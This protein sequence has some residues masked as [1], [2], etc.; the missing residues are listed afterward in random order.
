[1]RAECSLVES[2]DPGDLNRGLISAPSFSLAWLDLLRWTAGK[3]I[4]KPA[5]LAWRQEEY[6]KV[7][8][9]VVDLVYEIFRS[10]FCATTVPPSMPLPGSRT[11]LAFTRPLVLGIL[12]VTPDSF[13]DGGRFLAA[14]AAVRRAEE[15]RAEGADALDLGAESTRPGARAVPAKLQKERLVP[16]LKALR[17]N[18]AFSNI[19][20]SV[21]T[22][23][24]EVA[25]ACLGEGADLI[26]DIS[27]LCHD[28]Q[29]A[30]VCAKAKAPVILMHMQ[31]TP[32]TMQRDPQYKDVVEDLDLFFRERLHAAHE[33]GIPPTNVLLD[34]GFGFGKTLD[35]NCELLR[36]LGEFKALGRPLVVGVSRK[37]FLGK[38]TGIDEP[39]QRV[40]AS[41]A[42][43]AIA[44]ARGAR[45]LRVHDVAEH[46][47]ALKVARAVT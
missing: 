37:S 22:R 19:P 14:E 25:R 10:G 2:L 46:V 13:S 45:I 23:S 29:M 32:R 40:T 3:R 42:A 12:N 17:R 41:V 31:G 24:A 47:Q 21:D 6:D 16:V 35:H 36:R 7:T 11:Q 34:P 27:A 4:A 38:L 1:M 33:A 18:K 43:A 28:P 30:K 20:L 44:V 26:N 5:W 8:T 9:P 15:M 39:A